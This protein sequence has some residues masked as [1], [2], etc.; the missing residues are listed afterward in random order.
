MARPFPL[1][2]SLRFRLP[3]TIALLIAIVLATFIVAAYRIVASTLDEGSR[4]RALRS[5]NAVARLIEPQASVEAAL[6]RLADEP[7]VRRALEEPTDE[8]RAAARARLWA[9]ATSG[10]RRI[11]IWG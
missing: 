4:E 2:Q 1:R 10:P 11:E 5:A 9:L 8:N 6:Q 3:A 7:A